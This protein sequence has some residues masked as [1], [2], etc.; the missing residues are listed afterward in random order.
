MKKLADKFIEA[1]AD[2]LHDAE[3]AIKAFEQQGQEL[4]AM[5][6]N[7][8]ANADTTGEYF[9]G[10]KE[11]ETQKTFNRVVAQLKE[12]LQS[13]PRDGEAEESADPKR[14]AAAEAKDFMAKPE[15]KKFLKDAISKYPD[16]DE[17]PKGRQL[18]IDY[19][20]S[21]MQTAGWM[22]EFD[23]EMLMSVES[24]L[25]GLIADEI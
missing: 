11:K 7:A 22:D 1:N 14:S 19:V 3:M 8:V 23:K 9:T 24:E 18:V 16:Y 15:A 25:E 2:E 13:L 21:H 6:M 17:G 12:V 10:A 5:A 20:I 4:L